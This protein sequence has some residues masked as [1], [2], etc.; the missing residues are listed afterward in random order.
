VA[1]PVRH[2]ATSDRNFYDRYYF[3][4]HPK[5]EDGPF[6]VV[7][8]GQYPNLGVM[9]A[10]VLARRGPMHRVVR[11]SR[12]L[13][14]DRRVTDVGPIRVEVLEGLKRLRVVLEPNEWDVELDVT[15]EGA[16]PA[17]RE[18]QHVVREG[19]GRL[20]FDS[21]RFAQTGGWTG[22]VRVGGEE[23]DVTPERWWGSRDRSWGIRPVGE[24]EHPGIR[25]GR[26]GGTFFWLYAPMQFPDFSILVIAQEDADGSRVLEEAVRVWP[27]GSGRAPEMLGR[28]E[29]EIEFV[30]GTSEVSK[31][32]LRFGELS[33][34]VEPRL[35]VH[36][37][38]GTG[39]GLDADWRHGMWQGPLKVEGVAY[40]LDDPEDAARMWGIVDHLARFE[41]EG[42]EGWGLFETMV[43]GPHHRYNPTG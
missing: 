21:A 24:A 37:G 10:F 17:Q 4:L 7:G 41:V 43:I 31:A 15:W 19:F 13:G 27:E 26:P 1:E 36:I 30:P 6:V 32:V 29:H 28:P 18:P 14:D 22:R 35:P 40:D 39:Y 2:V 9:D 5:G 34:T 3:N 8:M 38:I 12:E 33:V 20:V 11:A 16:I 42:A 25:A 23:W